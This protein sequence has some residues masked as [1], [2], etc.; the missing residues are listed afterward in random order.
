MKMTIKHGL[1]RFC[2]LL[3]LPLYALCKLEQRLLPKDSEHIF[4]F[5]AQLL[6]VLP[7]IPGAFIR[8]G[9]YT[10]TLEEC[11]QN[12]HIGFGAIISHRAT[13]IKEFVYIGNYALIG[14]AHL[15]AHC[16]VGSRASILSGKALHVVGEDGLWTPFSA[17]RLEKIY[18]GNN[19]WLGEGA[20]IAA[21]IGENSMVGAGGVVSSDVK[22]N[23]VVAGNPARFVK[24]LSSPITASPEP[25]SSSMQKPDIDSKPRPK[26]M[27]QS[28]PSASAMAPTGEL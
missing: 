2:Q 24:N 18:I 22:A 1:H 6:A 9:F 21:N 20:I 19:V 14:S 23:I 7:G 8:R 15:G 10:L 3:T 11:S 16:L 25:K 27:A 28:Q 12:V 5:C 4:N 26:S 13:Q 17:D